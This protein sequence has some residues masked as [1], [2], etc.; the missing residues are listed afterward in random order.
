[1]IDLIDT[2]ELA[3]DTLVSLTSQR[4]EFLAG[5]YISV[6]WDMLELYSRQNEIV[7]GD[8][9]VMRMRF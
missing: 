6:N 2:P 7:E 9:L 3:A 4:R 5:R 1:M 8:K